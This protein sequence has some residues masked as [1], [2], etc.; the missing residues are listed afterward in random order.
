VRGDVAFRPDEEI[1][2][3]S[4]A[5]VDMLETVPRFVFLVGSAAEIVP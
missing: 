5:R 2:A 1:T 4:C 3:V